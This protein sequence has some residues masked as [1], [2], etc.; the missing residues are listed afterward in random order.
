MTDE[1]TNEHIDDHTLERL[2]TYL[3]KRN[4]DSDRIVVTPKEVMNYYREQKLT[5]PT[6]AFHRTLTYIDDRLKNE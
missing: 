4:S 2:I 5:E 6:K 3:N 1:H